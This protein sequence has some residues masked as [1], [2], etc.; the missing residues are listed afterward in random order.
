[1]ADLNQL[2]SYFQPKIG[3]I[4]TFR[5]YFSTGLFALLPIGATIAIIFW[6]LDLLNKT[7]LQRILNSPIINSLNIQIP[8]I[9]KPWVLGTLGL[10]IIILLV[11]GLGMLATNVVGRFF[12]SWIDII[13]KKVPLVNTIYSFVQGLADNLQVMKAGTFKKVVLIEYPRN[14][15]YSLGFVSGDLVGKIKD[16][17][18][19]EK[20][21]VF[22]PT[23][24]NPTSGFIVVIDSNQAVSLDITPEE[25][26]KFIVS[27]GVLM[28]GTG[29]DAGSA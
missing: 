26:L 12:I 6:L 28:P 10:L 7:F 18:G 14:G 9:L 25:G 13:M 15:I 20:I 2:K 3:D 16:S 23:S 24:P 29:K 17:A 27:G 11:V 8:E 4:A 5:R 19:E 1:M 21:A 22:V